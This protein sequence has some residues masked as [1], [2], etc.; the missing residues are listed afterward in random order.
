MER[1]GDSIGE[2]DVS[3]IELRFSICACPSI[4]CAMRHNSWLCRPRTPAALCSAR[5]GLRAITHV[6]LVKRGRGIVRWDIQD[7]FVRKGKKN[8][9]P[10][11]NWTAGRQGGRRREWDGKR[12]NSDDVI[13]LR[14]RILHP[15]LPVFRFTFF[16]LINNPVCGYL[17]KEIF[18]LISFHRAWAPLCP[19]SH[20][21]IPV[22]VPPCLVF[23]R[24]LR[25]DATTGRVSPLHHAPGPITSCDSR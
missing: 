13:E 16:P 18:L 5:R 11:T 17:Q 2:R 12:V 8:Q 6:F 4:D 9:N 1:L 24:R 25:R 3:C 22:D 23:A 21:C 14:R 10:Q 20:S 7:R 15:P 19:R